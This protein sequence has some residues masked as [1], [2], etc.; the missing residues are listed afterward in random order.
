MDRSARPV[1]CSDSGL[2]RCRNFLLLGC[3]QQVGQASLQQSQ[4]WKVYA[5]IHMPILKHVS[6]LQLVKGLLTCWLVREEPRY[7]EL[8]QRQSC[9]A[10]QRISITIREKQKTERHVGG[11]GSRGTLQKMK[12]PPAVLKQSQ[13]KATSVPSLFD[14]FARW[15]ECNQGR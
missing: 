7:E 9:P 6:Q 4:S 5:Q 8:H 14:E 13:A 2:A 1:W 3:T 11:G 10:Q 12:K 15:L